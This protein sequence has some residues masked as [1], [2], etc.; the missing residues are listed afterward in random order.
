MI[1]VIADGKRFFS[2][3]LKLILM[4]CF[5]SKAGSV[6]MDPDLLTWV[7]WVTCR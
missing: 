7:T 1:E 6:E 3:I 4:F 5:I 2:R